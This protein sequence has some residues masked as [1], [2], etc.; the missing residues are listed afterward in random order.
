ME[1]PKYTKPSIE[2]LKGTGRLG[3]YPSELNKII[4]DNFP[5]M[6]S[7]Y[8]V[9]FDHM[10]LKHGEEKANKIM[11]EFLNE[12]IGLIDRLP[13]A[14]PENPANIISKR[15]IE[16]PPPKK[17]ENLA[18]WYAF[19]IKQAYIN[20]K[21]EDK[22]WWSFMKGGPNA[23]L[24]DIQFAENQISLGIGRKFKINSR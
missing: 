11:S 8:S 2:E 24:T 6:Q 20:E 4:E 9:L 10:K 18:D 5:K 17:D 12:N 16:I 7:I 14:L 1:I 19:A 22:S 23:K 13:R 21:K 15:I 3:S